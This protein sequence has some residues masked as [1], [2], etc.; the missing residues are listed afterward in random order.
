MLKALSAPL[1]WCAVFP[2]PPLTLQGGYAAY[3]Y[4][5]PAAAAAAAYSDRYSQLVESWEAGV[6][7]RRWAQTNKKPYTWFRASGCFLQVDTGSRQRS[8]GPPGLETPSQQTPK[9][10]NHVLPA[11]MG[12]PRPDPS[13]PNHPKLWRPRAR[14]VIRSLCFSHWHASD[15]SQCP[16][17][18]DPSASSR[19]GVHR[20]GA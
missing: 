9:F 11:L 13:T 2:P 14:R 20:M 1:S 10:H 4:A 19:R 3:R 16:W 7:G 6:G 15:P 5:Q 12:R 8:A 17:V 18:R